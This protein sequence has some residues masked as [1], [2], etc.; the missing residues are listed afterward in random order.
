M[1]AKE[2]KEYRESI[3]KIIHIARGSG[4]TKEQVIN[5]IIVMFHLITHPRPVKVKLKRKF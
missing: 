2:A 5:D 3:G 1:N 4:Y